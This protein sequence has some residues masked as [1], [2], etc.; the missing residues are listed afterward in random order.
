MTEK[1]EKVEN[2]RNNKHFSSELTGESEKVEVQQEHL[3]EKGD[4][5]KKEEVQAYKPHNP[6]P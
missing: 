5:K 2:G 6:F 1:E 4:L 3:V